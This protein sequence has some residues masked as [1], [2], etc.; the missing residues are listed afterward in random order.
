M[1]AG[2]QAH[3]FAGGRST[4]SLQMV[5]LLHLADITEEGVTF[6]S[7]TDGRRMLLTPEH[8]IQVQGAWHSC[9][10]CG[11]AGWHRWPTGLRGADIS[12]AL[13]HAALM[14][15]RTL[16]SSWHSALC[17]SPV[18]P[19]TLFSSLWHTALLIQH[20]LPLFLHARRSKTG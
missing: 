8:S 20:A 2:R 10:W 1:T 9:C 3:T 11:G 4:P 5:S 19:C 18:A 6:Q 13:H 17:P 7:P 16:F 15:L 12:D 14:A